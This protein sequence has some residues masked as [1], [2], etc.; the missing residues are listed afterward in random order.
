MTLISPEALALIERVETA[1]ADFAAEGLSQ[2]AADILI[3]LDIWRPMTLLSHSWLDGPEKPGL[4]T[5]IALNAHCSGAI[6]EELQRFCRDYA[7]PE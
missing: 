6:F 2:P 5:R 4:A 7:W 3:G 1:R